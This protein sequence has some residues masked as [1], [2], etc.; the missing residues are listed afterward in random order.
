MSYFIIDIVDTL[1]P[2][3]YPEGHKS[4]GERGFFVSLSRQNL[5]VL[6]TQGIISP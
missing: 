3:P 1:T 6:F 4:P 2:G 5:L